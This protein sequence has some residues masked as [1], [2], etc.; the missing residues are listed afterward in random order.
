MEKKTIIILAAVGSGVVILAVV[1]IA[2]G[3]ASGSDPSSEEEKEAETKQG[4]TG[5]T[6]LSYG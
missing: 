1:G 6:G 2:V 4:N 3:V 5:N